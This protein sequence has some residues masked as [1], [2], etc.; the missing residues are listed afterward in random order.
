VQP[1]PLLHASDEHETVSPQLCGPVHSTSHAHELLHATLLHDAEPLQ[2]TSQGPDPHCTPWHDCL[3]VQ[4]MLH[5]AA[6]WQLMPLRHELSVLHM[7]SH[8]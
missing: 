3:P 2:L 5:D 1:L 7:M 4:S 6:I 8:L